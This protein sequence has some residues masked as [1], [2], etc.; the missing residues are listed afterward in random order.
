MNTPIVRQANQENQLAHAI[1][2]TRNDDSYLVIKQKEGR[3]PIAYFELKGAAIHW[4]NASGEHESIGGDNPLPD[5]L[6]NLAKSKELYIMEMDETNNI[7][8]DFFVNA[9]ILRL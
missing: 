9:D 8:Y 5:S 1:A 2:H 3:H 6:I 7:I 4:V